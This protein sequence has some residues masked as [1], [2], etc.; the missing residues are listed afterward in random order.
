[1]GFILTH[2]NITTLQSRKHQKG[3]VLS[4]SNRQNITHGLQ[5][6]GR[7]IEITNISIDR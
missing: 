7:I 3:N 5:Q 4:S 6:L 2:F 1:M